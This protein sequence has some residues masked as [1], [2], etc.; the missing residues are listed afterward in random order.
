MK[1][2]PL[3]ALPVVLA[4]LTL[5]G[6]T[7]ETPEK[8]IASAKEYLQKNDTKAAVI[9]I[10]NALQKNPNSGEA[11]FLLGSTLLKEGNPAAAE[12]ELRKAQAA[13][14]PDAQVVPELARA[15]LMLGQVKKVVDEFGQTQLG[16]PGSD[17]KLQTLLAAAYG[18]QGKPDQAKAALAAALAVEPKYTEALLVSAKQKAAERDVDGALVVVDDI[19]AREPGNADALK[20]KG[21]L[22]LYGKRQPDEALAA[23]RKTLAAA[24]R[25]MAA[26]VAIVNILMQ[27]GKLDDAAQQLGE[28]KKFAAK[29]PQTRFMEAQLAYQ[30]KDFN[31]AREIAQGLVQQAPNNPRVLELA[32]AVELQTG[33]PA[34]AQIYLSKAVQLAPALPLARRLLIASYLRTG[35]PAKA[36]D[37]LNAA[38]G[39]RDL[40]A[41]LYSVAGEVYLQNGDAKK[42]EE[43][44]AKALKL[45]PDDTRKRTAL[46]VTHLAAGK[47]EA[48]LG[49][50]QGIAAA[51]SGVTADL[52]L[53]SAYLRAK[54]Y[55]KAL[56]AIDRLE[57]KQ[58]DNPLA[59]NL[60]GRVLLAQKDRAG[61]RKSLERALSIDPGYFAAAASLAQLDLADK[62]PNDAKKRFE[63]LLTKNPKNAQAL[64]ALAQL[65]ASQKE[66]KE[67]IAGL[68]GKAIDANPTDATPRLLL[69]DL[70]LR[71]SDNKQA[72]AV[73]QGAVA[74]LPN[75]PELLATL[76]R[77]QLALGETNQAVATFSKLAAQQPLSPRSH[78]LLA[79]AQVANKDQPAA[80]QSLDKALEIKPDELDAQRAL[81]VLDLEARSFA[82]ANGIARTVQEQR[83]KAPIGYL[84]EGDIANARK[85]WDAAARAYRA[86]QQHGSSP[87]IATKL[88]A[89][90]L[91]AGKGGEAQR[92]ADAWQK[93]HPRDGIFLVYLGDQALAQKDYVA[94]ERIYEA[95]LALQPNSAV[96]LNNLAWAKG[97]LK[98]DGALELA[99]RANN[100]APN[101]PV[102]MDTFAV[103][104]ADKGDFKR[105]IDLLTKALELQPA[106]AQLRLNL[107]KI[108][109]K[110][111]ETA[112]AKAELDA[113]AK[114]GDRFAAHAEVTAMLATL[115]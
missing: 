75:S 107:A 32:G 78:I 23:Y 17:A 21:D 110:S 66:P 98:R 12:V 13:K 94:A 71:D 100:L 18:A 44:F 5:A 60:R 101:Q 74:A 89:V 39:K 57:A 55:G 20:F 49:E 26:H 50:L 108:Y 64:L 87:E 70:Y 54:D 33:A 6:C 42:A 109:V 72:L 82:D 19:I 51:D 80:R 15:M 31:A 81:I 36:L 34:Q 65:A 93:D 99:E 11:R 8:R 77:L 115:R 61:A 69:I 79:G 16:A 22:V 86:A 91:A 1:R 4:A 46:A 45:D 52:A 85:D 38:A 56:A 105:A 113:L 68:L 103:L 73:A 67:E 88:H 43:Y 10:K 40:P 59:A 95:A 41:A 97:Q 58:P 14:Y 76:G 114:L 53:I 83:P 48:A 2:K 3:I 24:P 27:Q 62:K 102:I 7:D 30:K 63:V 112:R 84:L 9:E 37:E 96:V 47:N 92:F 35:Q 25:Y 28:L 90:L 104:L 111:G 106:N 29:N